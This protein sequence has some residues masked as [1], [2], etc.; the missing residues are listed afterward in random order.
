MVFE[1]PPL[2]ANAVGELLFGLLTALLQTVPAHIAHNLLIRAQLLGR[3]N[4][5]T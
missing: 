4:H 5:N 3:Q 2:L 1:F